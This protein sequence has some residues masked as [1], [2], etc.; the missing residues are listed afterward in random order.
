M[1]A[2]I[3]S[4]CGHEFP[5]KQPIFKTCPTCKGLNQVGAEECQHC[6]HSFKANYVLTFGEALRTGAIVRGMDIGEAEVQEAE[7]IAA[8]VRKRV[9]D[10]GDQTL[11]NIIKILPEESWARLKNIMKSD[12]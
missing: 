8:N 3:Y 12:E 4:T 5:A 10:S 7:E 1:L 9:L 6:G 11:I 2:I